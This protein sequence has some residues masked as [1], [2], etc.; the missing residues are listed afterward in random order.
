MKEDKYQLLKTL[1]IFLEN[2]KENPS[3]LCHKILNYFAEDS[4]S[5]ID[6]NELLYN[7]EIDICLSQLQKLE[8]KIEYS[9]LNKDVFH[10]I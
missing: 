7:E 2:Q 6:I 8:K 1:R 9:S 4:L 10:E 5:L 3:E